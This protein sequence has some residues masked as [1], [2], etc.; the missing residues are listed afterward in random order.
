MARIAP[1]TPS[2]AAA[3]ANTPKTVL[4]KALEQAIR[5]RSRLAPAGPIS[6]LPVP[7]LD[8]APEHLP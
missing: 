5:R 2:E 1:L 3:L 6:S 4:E 8:L 7:P